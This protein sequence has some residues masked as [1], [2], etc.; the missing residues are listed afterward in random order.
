MKKFLKFVMYVV[1]I[2]VA[3]V[4]LLVATLPLWLGPVVKPAANIAVPQITQTKFNLGHLYLNPYTGRFE[5]GEMVLGNPEGYDEPVAVSLSNLVVDVAMNTVHAK[6]IHVEEVTVDGF[7]AS[8]VKGGE[9]GVDNFKQIQYNVAGGKEAYE[10]KQAEAEAKKAQDKAAEEAEAEAEKA[11]LEKMTAEERKEYERLKE[12]EE[13]AAEAAAKKLVIDKLVINN[14]R[15][16]YGLVTIPVPSITLT[17]IGKESDGASLGDIVDQIWQ[18]I[19]KSALA[20]GDGAKALANATAEGAKALA[21]ATAEGAKAAASAVG[22]GAAAAA[23]AVGDGASAAASAVS[24]GTSAAVG[25]V[26]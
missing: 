9:N 26:S 7:F 11:K 10:L 20:V 6:Y 14:I 8:Y 2:A 22:D 24:D 16:K 12:A 4:V 13:A 1:L 18:A 21:N 5:V 17:D 19:L 23:S 3:L 25:A 15:V